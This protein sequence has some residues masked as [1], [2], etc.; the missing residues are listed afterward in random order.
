MA[1]ILAEEEEEEEEEGRRHVRFFRTSLFL[2][3]LSL[4]QPGVPTWAPP[5]SPSPTTHLPL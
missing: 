3:E 5:P 4:P 2:G 1:Q